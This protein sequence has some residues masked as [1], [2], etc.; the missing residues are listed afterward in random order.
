MNLSICYGEGN[1]SYCDNF[2]NIHISIHSLG[3]YLLSKCIKRHTILGLGVTVMNKTKWHLDSSEMRYGVWR[4][5]RKQIY[6]PNQAMGLKVI[7]MV[8]VG[9]VILIKVI[10]GCF[11]V[12]WAFEQ[13]LDWSKWMSQVNIWVKFCLGKGKLQTQIP[14]N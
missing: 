8:V 6:I 10:K 2:Y 7:E 5:G 12:I 1:S 9:V 3:Y 4:L 14:E 13:R 11:S